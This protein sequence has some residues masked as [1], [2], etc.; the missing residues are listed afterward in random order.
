MKAAL[1]ARVSTDDKGQDLGLQVQA[2]ARR[3]GVEGWEVLPYS[4]EESAYSKPAEERPGFVEM[5][6]AVDAYEVRAVVCY[7]MDRFSR[8]PPHKVSA[9]L[10]HIVEERKCR[11]LTVT[12]GID[13]ASPTWPIVERVMAWTA[14]NWSRAH[15]ERVKAGMARSKNR[16]GR[17]ALPPAV[18]DEA[19]RLRAEG[20][21]WSQIA[22]A[23]KIG[24]TSARRACLKEQSN[25]T[26]AEGRVPTPLEKTS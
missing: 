24:A 10:H 25:S 4:D 14:N 15:G 3:C 13:S 26:L 6:K 18:S 23:L 11:F 1:Y 9:L 19:R 8:E 7:S 17:P 12:D 5:M 2:C 21:S 16:P 22:G 20:K